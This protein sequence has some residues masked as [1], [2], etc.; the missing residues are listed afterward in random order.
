[1]ADNSD[2]LIG[3]ETIN[4]DSIGLDQRISSKK[5]KQYMII[6]QMKTNGCLLVCLMMKQ[7]LVL[8]Q[9]K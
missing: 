4:A 3:G 7:N 9:K 2:V 6:F 5:K 8:I 1:M